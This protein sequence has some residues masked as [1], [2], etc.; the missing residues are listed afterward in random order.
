MSE[1]PGSEAMNRGTAPS[2]EGSMGGSK[3]RRKS[4]SDDLYHGSFVQPESKEEGFTMKKCIVAT[5]IC[6]ICCEERGCRELCEGPEKP[7]QVKPV[8]GN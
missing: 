1:A 7:A 8:G 3:P 5:I 6:L 4:I 2:A